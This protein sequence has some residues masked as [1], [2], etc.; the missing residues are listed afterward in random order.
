MNYTRNKL[1]ITLINK[2]YSYFSLIDAD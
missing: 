1:K 2:V